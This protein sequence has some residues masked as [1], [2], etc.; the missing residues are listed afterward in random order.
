MAAEDSASS[1]ANAA[2]A[3]V[4]GSKSAVVGFHPYLTKFP[5]IKKS[6]HNETD[7]QAEA[8]RRC[9]QQVVQ[10]LLEDPSS[11]LAIFQAQEKRRT[12][13]SA[14]NGSVG[15]DEQFDS[16]TT[17]GRLEMP[18]AIEMI[19]L[20]GDMVVSDLILASKFDEQA[21]R[22][23]LAY[24][25]GWTFGLKIPKD[26]IIKGVMK[27][28]ILPRAR[29]MGDRLKAWKADGG[30]R[31]DGSLNWRRGCYRL[32]FVGSE[33]VSKL[34]EIEHVSGMKIKIPADTA[35]DRKWELISN[36]P[37]YKAP[38]VLKPSKPS[39]IIK[40]FNPRM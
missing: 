27:E 30:F 33:D 36:W 11:A 39:P 10:G 31:A 21:P 40:F 20:L 22:Q 28:V 4:F 9:S 37:D 17:V 2:A 12:K 35:I 26:G 19:W 25:T 38:L 8:L 13:S 14:L 23:L 32:C 24:A 3:S 29:V 5:A 1:G 18:F 34:S 7:E 16:V 15:R 6:G